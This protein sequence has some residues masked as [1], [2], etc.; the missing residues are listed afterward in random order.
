[1]GVSRRPT[2]PGGSPRPLARGM[3]R[4]SSACVLPTP[5]DT[6]L[7]LPRVV[8]DAATVPLAAEMPPAD[9]R[10]VVEMCPKLLCV[11]RCR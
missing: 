4:W 5:T 1:M 7:A 9:L 6:V 8:T 11:A 3:G 2:S 10:R